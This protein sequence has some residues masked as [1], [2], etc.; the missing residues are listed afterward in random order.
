MIDLRKKETLKNA[1]TKYEKAH[2]IW[3]NS[4][5]F[6]GDYPEIYRNMKKAE[7]NYKKIYKEENPGSIV[8]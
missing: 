2:E 4:S 1:L 8:I 5:V 3:F 7:E 6:D